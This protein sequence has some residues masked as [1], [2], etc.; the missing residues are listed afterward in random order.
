[1]YWPRKHL[2]EKHV[3]HVVVAAKGEGGKKRE[4]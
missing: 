3:I 4:L 1:M 2:E